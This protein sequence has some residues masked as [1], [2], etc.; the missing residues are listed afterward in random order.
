MAS[1]DSDTDT[2]GTPR[3]RATRSAVRW[4]VPVSE[5]ATVG[6]GTRCTLARAMR[7]VSLARMMAPSIFAS[8]DRRWGEKAASRRKPPEQIPST[9]GS[10]PTTTSAP[11]R[12]W[13]IRSSPSRS[14]CPGAT[15]AR[16]ASMDKLG[17]ATRPC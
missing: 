10:S 12:A 5:V 3:E 6:S 15:A 4:R 1:R 2:T 11:S 13:R 16:A 9:A 14:G 7:P 8:S 17:A